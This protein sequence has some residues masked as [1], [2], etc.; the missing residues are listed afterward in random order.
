MLLLLILAAVF[1]TLHNFYAWIIIIITYSIIVDSIPNGASW[2]VLRK[3]LRDFTSNT[4]Q[5]LERERA[6]LLSRTALLDAENKQLTD[7]IDTHLSK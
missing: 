2:A 1:H 5:D 3:E 7:Y 4:Q 6:E